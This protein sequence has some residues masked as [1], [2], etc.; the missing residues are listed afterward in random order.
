MRNRRIEASRL[1]NLTS[2]MLRVARL[3]REDV[4]PRMEVTDLNPLLTQLVDQ[5]SRPPAD[6]GFRSR[7]GIGLMTCWPIRS[8]SAWL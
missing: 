2:K 6:R 4:K 5:Y 8:Y 1:G 3:D 7:S